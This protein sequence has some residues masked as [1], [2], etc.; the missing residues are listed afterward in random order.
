MRPP[1][2]QLRTDLEQTQ[3]ELNQ[4]RN[5]LA[6]VTAQAA[7]SGIA[8]TAVAAILAVGPAGG[9]DIARDPDDPECVIIRVRG[10]PFDELPDQGQVD[11]STLAASMSDG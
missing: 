8:L 10:L 4:A 5:D 6:V 2:K 1:R 11:S 9:V 3:Q 7:S